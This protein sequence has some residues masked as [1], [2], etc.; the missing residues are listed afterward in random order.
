[1]GQV[2]FSMCGLKAERGAAVLAVE[3]AVVMTRYRARQ[4]PVQ[5]QR[6]LTP[7]ET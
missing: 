4:S 5:E 1:M 7:P 3:C 6:Q 2:T